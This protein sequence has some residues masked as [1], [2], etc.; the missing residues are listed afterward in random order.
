MENKGRYRTG[1]D[2]VRSGSVGICEWCAA[3]AL[4]NRFIITGNE[5][6]VEVIVLDSFWTGRTEAEICK[7]HALVYAQ[8]I[9]DAAR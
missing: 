1:A 8:A 5:P 6:K 7:V 4:D 3:E 9:F 2:L